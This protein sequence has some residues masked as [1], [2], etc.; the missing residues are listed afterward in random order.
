MAGKPHIVIV[1]AGFGGLNAAKRLVNAPVRVTLIDR[2]NYHLFQP[3]LYQVATAGLS[4]SEIAYPLRAIFQ[5]QHNLDFLL[6]EV[7]GVDFAARCVQTDRGSVGYDYLIIAAGAEVNFFS[8]ESLERNAFT[9]KDVSDAVRL[10]NH[11]LKTFELAVNENDPTKRRALMTFV[12]VGGGPTGVESAGALSEL[13]RLVL[14]RDHPHLNLDDVKV[15]LLEAEDSILPGFPASLQEAAVK[16]LERKHVTVQLNTKVFSYDGQAV[17]AFDGTIIPTDTVVWSAGVRVA[18]LID[19]LGVEQ[20]RLGR[21]KVLPTLQLPTYPEIYIIG[22]V[23]YMEK[24]GLP[25]PMMAPVAVQQ[26]ETAVE[27]ILAT[28]QNKRLK[29]FTFKD[30]GS[31]ATIGRNA[32]VA[33]IGAWQFKGFIAW[34]VWLVVHLIG[35][36]GF[37][38][39][40]VVLINWAWDYFFYDRAVRLIT[41]E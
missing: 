23:A 41:P 40:L 21:V 10:R 2:H 13:I 24:D 33:R 34:V 18:G 29:Y 16:A 5:K 27:N 19:K 38:N 17:T 4:P 32:A 36:I 1:G 30:P 37:R 31:L 26:A 39:R 14:T 28:L 9:L 3:L 22:D 11:F 7:T 20:V 15:I 12:V 35:L 25:L 8:A 6:A